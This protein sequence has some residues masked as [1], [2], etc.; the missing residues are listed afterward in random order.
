MPTK[1]DLAN[2]A[3][4]EAMKMYHDAVMGVKS[5]IQDI[6]QYFPRWPLKEATGLW[7]AAFVYHC[8]QLA[9][10]DFPIRPKECASCNLA[11]CGA[12]EEW[13]KADNRIGWRSKTCQP[14]PGDIVIFD[15]VFENKIHDHIGIVLENRPNT[16]LTAEGNINGVSGILERPKDRHIRGYI[17]LPDGFVYEEGA[18]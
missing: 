3:R 5:N 17:S 14:M 15:K 13:A 10:Y 18:K 2:T 4:A 1:L 11:G 8:C 16:I 9:G 12:W 7:C 6:I